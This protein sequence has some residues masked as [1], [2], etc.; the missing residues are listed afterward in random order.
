[1]FYVKE[2]ISTSEIAGAIALAV[3]QYIRKSTL[4]LGGFPQISVFEAP[5]DMFRIILSFTNDK[6]EMVSVEFELHE[7]VAFNIAKEFKNNKTYEV[8]IFE[9]VEEALAKLGSQFINNTPK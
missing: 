5:N 2:K 3:L 4:P 7:K 1:M 8:S 9:P 6:E